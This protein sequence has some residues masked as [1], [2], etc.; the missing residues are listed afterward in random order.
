MRN[1]LL[2]LPQN[3]FLAHS[4]TTY[5][6]ILTFFIHMRRKESLRGNVKRVKS[7]ELF[8]NISNV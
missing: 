5:I 2:F 3:P 6:I 7:I 4:I 8:I 1:L